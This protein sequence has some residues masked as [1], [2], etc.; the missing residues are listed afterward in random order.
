MEVVKRMSAHWCHRLDQ[1]VRSRGSFKVF[2][3]IS[4]AREMIGAQMV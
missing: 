1:A 3:V 4:H 2:P